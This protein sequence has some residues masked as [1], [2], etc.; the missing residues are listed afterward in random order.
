MPLLD[1]MQAKKLLA[2]Y[3][4]GS[5]DSK[6]ISSADDA[7]KFANGS[8]IVMKLIS[9]KAIHKSREGLVK[10]G[11]ESSEEISA[12]YNYLAKRGKKL[13][14][15]KVLAQKMASDGIE[16]IIGG[17]T[18]KQ[19]GKMLLVGLGGIYVETFH[20]V[21][22]RLCPITRKD[23]LNMLSELKSGKVITY[24]GK[25]TERIVAL[26]LNVSRMLATN[27]KISELDLNPVIVRPDSYDV[28]D[29][30]ILE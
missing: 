22:L 27:P 4:I 1:Y 26:L 15:F 16:I 23:A 25:A 19:F 10:L 8:K 17:N 24:S 18:D 29:I 12:A 9:G 6:Y 14:P 5:I 20:D 11:L 21:Q 2:R 13:R 30:R 7:V 28:V 3:G